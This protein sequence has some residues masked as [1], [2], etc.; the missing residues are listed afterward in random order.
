M[1]PDSARI[2]LD[3]V[4]QKGGEEDTA[5]FVAKNLYKLA[6]AKKVYSASFQGGITLEASDYDDGP[7]QLDAT[8]EIAR[9]ASLYPSATVDLRHV[10][11]EHTARLLR[12]LDG[13]T[14]GKLPAE[15]ADEE[16]NGG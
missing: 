8:K 12:M 1:E 7:L 2:A 16:E 6:T 11:T 15:L 14:R 9:M 5:K 4:I 3:A 10:M 13:Q